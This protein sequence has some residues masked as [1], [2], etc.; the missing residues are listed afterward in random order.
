MQNPGSHD[1]L[2]FVAGTLILTNNGQVPI[3]NIKVGDMVLT[4]E[5]YKPVEITTSSYKKVITNLGLTGTSN[6][7]IITANGIKPLT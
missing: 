2:C 1:D 5:G 3:E 4:R 7:P 6:H